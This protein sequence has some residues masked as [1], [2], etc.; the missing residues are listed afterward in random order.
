M[1]ADAVT[2]AEI[3]DATIRAQLAREFA[4]RLD[5]EADAWLDVSTKKRQAA[6]AYRLE[7][8]KLT[9]KTHELRKATK[10]RAK[11]SIA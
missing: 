10:S 11:E 4:E 1:G 3:R 6:I 7:A 2:D 5:I 8:H 9:V